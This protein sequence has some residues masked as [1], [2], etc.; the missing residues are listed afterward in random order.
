V[1]SNGKRNNLE[2]TTPGIATVIISSEVIGTARLDATIIAAITS[3]TVAIGMALRLEEAGMM[4][5]TLVG[6]GRTGTITNG[7]EIVIP[8]ARETTTLGLTMVV[9]TNSW[10]VNGL[11]GKS[12]LGRTPRIRRTRQRRRRIITQPL[13]RHSHRQGSQ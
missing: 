1:V 9:G 12:D 7:I 13:L 3:M 2:V 8:V 4:K 10:T 5:G 11:S 6:I